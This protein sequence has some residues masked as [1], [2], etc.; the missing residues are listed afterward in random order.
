[1]KK[2][3]YMLTMLTLCLLLLPAFASADN[4]GS[5]SVDG[6]KTAS[7]RIGAILPL[8]GELSSKGRIRE[9]AITIATNEANNYLSK[10][11]LN[12]RLELMVK[13]SGSDPDQ[14]LR[15][16][17]QL[18]KEG[19]SIFIAGS[20]A[21]IAKLNKWSEEH[22]TVVISYSSTAPSLGI[23][24]DGIFRVVPNDRQQA[25]A[26]AT[27]LDQEG[28][29]Q[30]IPVYRNDVYGKELS[31]LLVSEFG[32]AAGKASSPVVYEP[33]TTDF[34]SVIAQIQER[35]NASGIARSATGIVLI[36]FDE[37][38]QLLAQATSLQDIRWFGSDTLTL[39]PS[40]LSDEKAATVAS[41]VYLTG[42]TFGSSD[43]PMYREVK[44]VLE[45]QSTSVV[46]PD[47]IFAYDIPWMLATVFQKM[48]TPGDAKELKGKLVQLSAAYA[49]ATGWMVLDPSGDRQYSNYDIWQVQGERSSYQWERLGKYRRDPGQPGYIVY[50]RQR[51]SGKETAGLNFITG[52]E[53]SAFQPNREVSRAE[54]V[55]M[56]TQALGLQGDV[57]KSS[58]TDANN[59]D[60]RARK[61][62]ALAVREGIVNG[63]DDGSFDPNR[64]VSRVEMLAMTVRSLGLSVNTAGGSSF[65]DEASIPVW[66]QGYAKVAAQQGILDARDGNRLAPN[67]PAVFAEAVIAILQVLKLK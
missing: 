50:D 59:I 15:Q 53:G 9:K 30:I 63:N 67:E 40:L 33:N 38:N 31:D 11:G 34:K 10:A 20:S 4:N 54:F 22:G 17:E 19:T 16:A 1:M 6:M 64:S 18:R 58:F 41:A 8:S 44:A 39:S 35:L 13:D 23:A 14:A 56:L 55:Y 49:G 27:L 57:A 25:K 51:D 42:V 45:Q 43:T 62:V 12:Y 65:A 28:I 5:S 47:A 61:A 7:I 24:D 66:A 32:Q 2:I 36:S 3:V 26:L 52:Y 48:D 37:A 29:R 21:E 60:E 46:I